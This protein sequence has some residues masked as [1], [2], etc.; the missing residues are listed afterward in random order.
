MKPVPPDQ[1]FKIASAFDIGIAAEIPY[2][3]NRDLCLTNKIFTYLLAGNCILASNTEAQENFISSYPSV[4]LLYK[5]DDAVDLAEKIKRL[6]YDRPTLQQFKMNSL[7]LASTELNWE[8]ESKKL[9]KAVNNYS[10]I[11]A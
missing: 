6:Y 8:N 3:E 7:Q 2:C 1:V 11:E 9:L 5:Y 4:G 10:Q